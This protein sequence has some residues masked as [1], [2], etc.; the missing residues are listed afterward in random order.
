MLEVMIST[1]PRPLALSLL[2]FVASTSVSAQDASL[3]PH[4]LPF[5]ASGNVL[6][7]AVG[8]ADAETSLGP[9]TVVVASAPAWLQWEADRADAV[10][11]EGDPS[12]PRREPVARLVFG[13]APTAPVGAPGEV[14]LHVVA[15]D[16]A[17]LAAHTVRVTASAPE[18]L[19]LS[20]PRPNPAR[21][22][23]VSLS[24]AVPEAGPVRLSVV[25]AL[26][27]EVAVV[28][29]DERAPGGYEARIPTGALASGVYAVRLVGGGTAVVRRLTVVR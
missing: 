13:V 23:V 20:A 21:G 17:V 22:G 19:S 11:P 10:V 26:G 18:R 9:F 7:L 2:F 27:R 8:T 3:A 15:P 6:E 12:G 5:G 4:R 24:Y 16:G 25:D 14:V 28:V 1:F 29:E